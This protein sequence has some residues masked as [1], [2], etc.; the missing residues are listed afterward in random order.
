MFTESEKTTPFS[1]TEKPRKPYGSGVSYV[2]TQRY[3]AI[4]I[5]IIMKSTP[6]CNPRFRFAPSRSG[7]RPINSST[8]VLVRAS[9]HRPLIYEFA[10]LIANRILLDDCS[11]TSWSNSTSTFTFVRLLKSHY[12]LWFSCPYCPVL[13]IFRVIFLFSLLFSIKMVSKLHFYALATFRLR[14]PV[15]TVIIETWVL[16]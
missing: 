3:L 10:L 6:Q 13:P 5:Y 15:L 11:N 1:P 9:S 4:T 8:N 7:I 12:F 14:I 2:W 16:P